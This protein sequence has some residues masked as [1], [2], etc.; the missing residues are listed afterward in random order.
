MSYGYDYDTLNVEMK[1]IIESD[2]ILRQSGVR[3]QHLLEWACAF[4]LWVAELR[5][6]GHQFGSY[7]ELLKVW[8]APFS[9]MFRCFWADLN[10]GT[11][12]EEF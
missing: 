12:L 10:F 7:D 2:D 9:R 1:R 5:A 11:L 6:G 8:K 4:D 3:V